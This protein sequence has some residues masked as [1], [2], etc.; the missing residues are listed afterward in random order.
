MTSTYDILG[1]GVLAV[2]D[3]LYAPEYPPADT[4]V[5]LRHRERQCGGLTGTALIAAA[6]LGARCAY[7][8]VLGDDEL[9]RF[10]LHT[11]EREGVDTAHVVTRPDAQPVHSSIVVDE[12]H[13]TRNIFYH[14]GGASG[15]ADDAPPAE[16][17]RAAKV[18]FVDP[19]GVTGMIRAARI[20]REANRPV[21]ADFEHRP[22]PDAGSDSP[23]YDELVGLVDHLVLPAAYACELAGVRDAASAVKALLTDDVDT[24][25]ATCGVEGAVYATRES[26][27]EV[28][29][30]P[31]FRV[32][33][34][35]TT[36]CG[37]V[38]HGAYAFG[39]ARGMNVVERV[40]LAA[41]A[42]ALKA[43]QPGGQKGIP[44]LPQVEAFLAERS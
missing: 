23:R 31:A 20:A 28:H 1:L 24:V 21:V 6:R 27:G 35:D 15:A 4:K 17:V 5:R 11:L 39:L 12:T 13:H 30:Q 40:R 16:V 10:V 7:A 26:P 9:S 34:V 44:T 43:T 3:L 41:A 2:D 19:Y 37:D 33:T 8:G 32:K 42:A 25:C 38:F 29:H 36:G 14:V 22:A 18:L